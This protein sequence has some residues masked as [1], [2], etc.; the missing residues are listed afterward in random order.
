LIGAAAL[1]HQNQNH[2]DN[3]HHDSP[4]KEA[5][6]ER[7]YRDGLHNSSYRPVQSHESAYREG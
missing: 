5:A 4:E 1:M 6:Y 7:G 2:K 3:K